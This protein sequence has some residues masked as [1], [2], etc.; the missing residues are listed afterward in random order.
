[1][2]DKQAQH[3]VNEFLDGNN[4]A[5]E[6]LFRATVGMTGIRK[7]F[8]PTGIRTREDFEQVA[9]IGLSRAIDTWDSKG[10]SSFLSWA[11]TL[12]TQSLIR[13]VKTIQRTSDVKMGNPMPFDSKADFN[14]EETRYSLEEVYYKEFL[15]S[16][17]YEPEFNEELFIKICS[18]VEKKISHNI[19]LRKVFELKVT[20]PDMSRNTIS[21]ITGY[22]KPSISDY[23]N[24]IN[25][26]IQEVSRKYSPY[27]DNV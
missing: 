27:Y 19:R 17:L 12:M 16:G 6:S 3:L 21:K 5:F 1:M 13:E 10:G 26:T 11:K 23:F 15:E 18:E 2:E 14:G 24:T 8:D 20:F 4:Q 22:S 25:K 9:K 7:Y